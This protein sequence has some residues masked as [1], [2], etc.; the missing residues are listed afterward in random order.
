MGESMGQSTVTFP[1]RPSYDIG[2][3]PSYDNW[4]PS[5]AVAPTTQIIEHRHT[6]AKDNDV[7][8]KVTKAATAA[9]TYGWEI[10]Y[11]GG[12]T[13]GVVAAI[14]D[15]DKRLREAFTNG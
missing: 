5:S 13:A 15:A 2:Y 3:P 1:G 8:V 7:K 14:L 9:G 4:T 11:E 12:S 6:T 10:T